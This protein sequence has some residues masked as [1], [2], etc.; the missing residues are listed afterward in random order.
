MVQV[1]V[2]VT[3]KTTT[4]HYEV[5]TKMLH[6]TT[7]AS[8]PP[9]EYNQHMDAILLFLR[10]CNAHAEMFL[11]SCNSG[12]QSPNVLLCYTLSTGS[13]SSHPLIQDKPSII[14]L[15]FKCKFSPQLPDRQKTKWS[16]SHFTWAKL[17]MPWNV[18]LYNNLN[19]LI[20]Q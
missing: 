1:K 11:N 19:T 16:L 18:N 17:S 5:I 6:S 2:A 8:V 12:R 4:G 10:S 14:I 13:K 15:I 9:H 7:P 20:H 3:I